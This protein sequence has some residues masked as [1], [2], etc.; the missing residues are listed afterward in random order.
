ME[1]F[2]DGVLA[3]A[4]TLLVLNLHVPDTAHGGLW[5]ALLREWPAY[6]SYLVSF[7][8]IGTIWVNHHAVF[9][10]IARGDR[11][12]LFLNLI[13]LMTIAFI[14]FPT[15]LLAS[16]LR[17]GGSAAHVAAAVYSGSMALMG[18]AFG[19]LW[20]YASRG[21]RLLRPGLTDADVAAMTR[22][23]VV[24][25]PIYML[26]IGIAFL[27]PGACL[28]INALLAVFYMLERGGA[29]RLAPPD[30]PPPRG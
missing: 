4:I 16:Y 27:S 26:A 18:A 30:E 7:L 1:A 25:T 21:R 2:S 10:Q 12:L 17:D 8:I 20:V 29:M 24:G 22:S 15:A 11:A 9:Q 13:L 3:I 14:P 28:A 5:H 19:G 23:F 6:A